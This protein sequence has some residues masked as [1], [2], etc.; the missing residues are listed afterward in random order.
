[1]PFVSEFIGRPVID[2]DGQ[3]L[4]RVKDLVAH[5]SSD[6]PHPVIDAIV[7]QKGKLTFITPYSG[8]VALV[9]AAIPLKRH[10]NELET[11]TPAEDDIFL[12][13]DVL[14]KQIIDTE[15]ARV[16][17]VNDLELL[18][19]NGTIYVGSVDVGGLGIIRRMG[20]VSLARH[21]ANWPRLGFL[22]SYIP[23]DDVEL[24]Q[25]D[26]SMRLRVP[27]EKIHNLH[28]ADIAE[29]ISDLNRHETG[30]FLE[31]LDM[32]H[33]ADTLEEVEPEYQASLVE[34][35]PDEQVADIL[36][37]MEPDEAADLLAEFPEERSKDLLALMEADDAEDVRRLLTYPVDSAGGLMTTEFAA[38][39]PDMTAEETIQYLRTC[40]DEA[41]TIFYVYVTDAEN[42]LVGVFSLSSLIFAQPTTRVEDFM[43]KRIVSVNLLDDQDDVAQV[44]SKY[45]M[46]AVPVVDE[47]NC[48]HGIV[49]ADDALD[50]I[51]PT[52]WK[53][54]LPRFFR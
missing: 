2:M 20:L 48:I 8:V 24:L 31:A 43:A 28:P 34:N 36:E 29:I 9:A 44:V 45:N 11:Y 19:I 30:Q 22:Q 12:A 6:F 46:L 13:R 33:L 52:A 32:E 47:N 40:A 35:M 21:A 39:K 1:M 15:G 41:E 14:D 23:W 51:I 54:R 37:E 17:R 38:V 25:H 16:V 27:V 50:K 49:T 18:R 7:V 26:Q 3:R 42:H 5:C 10:R 4:G 53:K